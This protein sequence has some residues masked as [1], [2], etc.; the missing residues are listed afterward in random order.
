M[1]VFAQVNP[2]AIEPSIDLPEPAAPAEVLGEGEG[3]TEDADDSAANDQGP[4]IAVEAIGL[5][6]FPDKAQLSADLEAGLQLRVRD[7]VSEATNGVTF[8]QLNGLAEE[9]TAYLRAEGVFLAQVFLPP[10]RVD[11]GAVILRV[12]PALVSGTTAVD[13]SVYPSSQIERSFR[14]FDGQ[15]A[16]QKS[17]ESK[18]LRVND[19][20]GIEASGSFKADEKPGHTRLLVNINEEDQIAYRTRIDNHNVESTGD[21]RLIVGASVNNL[22]GI[23]DQLE[24]DFFKTFDAGDLESGRVRYQVFSPNLVHRFGATYARSNY[25]TNSVPGLDVEGDN[26]TG[27]VFWRA[28]WIRTQ[29]FNLS[30]QLDLA[31]KRAEQQQR[32]FDRV[33]DRLTV[34]SASILITDVD[35]RLTGLQ[36]LV[37]SYHRGLNNTLGS[38][39]S[40]RQPLPT[41][42]NL[43]GAFEKWRATYQRLQNLTRSQ[44]LLL[45][46]AGQYSD[47]PLPSI[48]KLNLGGPY[49][50]RSHTLGIA[51]GDRSSFASLGWRADAGLITDSAA[52][53]EYNW[54]DI[55]EAELFVDWG[56][57]SNVD[58]GSSTEVAGAGAALRLTFPEQDL[59]AEVIWAK[60]FDDEE[61]GLQVRDEQWWFSV[62]A[63][64]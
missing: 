43:P 28:A 1:P 56:K 24:A 35:R 17:I 36:N 25:E 8:V 29:D 3:V 5:D 22:L 33:A 14:E 4:T 48:E 2:G 32:P 30:T 40:A 52:F 23:R 27:D 51:S 26:Y 46:L 21:L 53:G 20:P 50:V 49:S 55:L 58:T 54:A 44:N 47:D 6:Y 59:S 37:V 60:P 13:S 9:L 15:P 57:V 63:G 12:M 16:E 39:D 31:V 10:Q 18:L 34:A 62:S 19:L 61:P 41:I 64:F 11:N 7:F 45:R 38:Q 42:S